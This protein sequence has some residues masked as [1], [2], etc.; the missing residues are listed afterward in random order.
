MAGRRIARAVIALYLFVW[1]AALPL[2][3]AGDGPLVIPP[4]DPPPSLAALAALDPLDSARAIALSDDG[5]LV[6]FENTADKEWRPPIWYRSRATY[7]ELF[8][9]LELGDVLQ[10]EGPARLSR[11]MELLL[12]E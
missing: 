11:R 10:R 12:F 4:D 8:A 3:A 1:S 5:A 2:P 7:E 9:P 6:L